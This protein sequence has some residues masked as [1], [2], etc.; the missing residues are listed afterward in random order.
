MKRDKFFDYNVT[1]KR[2]RIAV[3]AVE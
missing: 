2:F 1:M 3:V